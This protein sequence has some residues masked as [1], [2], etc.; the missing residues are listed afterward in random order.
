MIRQAKE[1]EMG[2]ILMRPLTSG[3][4]R[5]LMAEAFPDIDAVASDGWSGAAAA[6][7]CALGPLRGRG[8]GGR[9]RGVPERAAIC[10]VK[11]RDLGRRRFADRPGKVARS[12]CQIERCAGLTVLVR[13][14][15]PGTASPVWPI[16]IILAEY[17]HSFHHDLF[18]PAQADPLAVTQLGDDVETAIERGSGRDKVP[19][20]VGQQVAQHRRSVWPW[21]ISSTLASVSR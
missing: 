19:V 2:V 1:Q 4:F 21:L 17:R 5:Q 11:Q 9:A 6:Q 16:R 3:V 15:S 10:G 12:V 13:Q 14:E 8:A 7:L 20:D 18:S